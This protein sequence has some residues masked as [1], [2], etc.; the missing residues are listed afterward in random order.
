MTQNIET[1]SHEQELQAFS[2]AFDYDV[3]YLER[4]LAATREGFEAFRAAQAFGQ[5][6][7]ALPLDVH[8]V[9]RIATMQQED[10]GSCGQLNVRMAL[11]AG[12]D[13][14]LLKQLIA[15]PR[16]LPQPLLDVYEHACI[17]ARSGDVDID[18][19]ERLEARYGVEGVAELAL[20]IAG[21]RI[22]PSMKRA[23]GEMKSCAPLRIDD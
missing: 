10:C 1:P 7:S 6:R 22:Y 13:R 8:Y 18:R 16:E 21:S 20:A 19:L 14:D 5:F 3:S 23:L 9:A 15:D 17:V 4:L 2:E 11:A 12:V